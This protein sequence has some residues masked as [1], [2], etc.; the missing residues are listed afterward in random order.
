MNLEK[1]F[2]NIPIIFYFIILLNLSVLYFS[3]KNHNYSVKLDSKGYITLARNIVEKKCF[4]NDNF[5]Y[6]TLRTPGYP[7]FIA[8]VY[9]I[10][11]SYV[12]AVL[13]SQFLIFVLSMCLF[14]QFLLSLFNNKKGAVWGTVFF[15]ADYIYIMHNYM[16][17]AENL[18]MFFIILAL[19]YTFRF[20]KSPNWYNSVISGFLW[21][22]P[23]FIKPVVLFFPFIIFIFN[24]K[25]IK[26]SLVFLAVYLILPVSWSIR[27][28]I[29]TGYFNY[30]SI[31]GITALRYAGGRII[32][33]KE[34]KPWIEVDEKLRGDIEGKYK[35][36]NDSERSSV[37]MKEAIKVIAN[38]KIKFIEIL[39]SGAFKT[40]FGVG[41]EMLPD[42][43]GL[44]NIVSV[45]KFFFAS[46]TLNM[47]YTYKWLILIFI[48]YVSFLISMYY[49]SVRGAIE[50]YR[51]KRFCELYIAV[52]GIVYFIG[53]SSYQGYYRFKI[54]ALVFF[55][56]LVAAYFRYRMFKSN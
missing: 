20:L 29:Y 31:G 45:K 17:M 16:I 35:F 52:S 56:L 50:L 44:N 4:C 47:L 8:F 55:A 1:V 2:K 53:I 25:R 12:N 54:P 15:S 5:Q 10:T 51:N 24:I 42:L 48:F 30:S 3:V 9:K 11:G 40:L 33:A 6:D 7:L 13:I 46:G 19:I 26:F 36:K 38:N 27:N 49:Y 23:C 34:N 32:A 14:Y 41:I 43:F 28:Y 21:G 39:I 18:M 37:Y 22:I